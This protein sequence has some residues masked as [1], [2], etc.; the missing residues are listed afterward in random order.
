MLVS[1]CDARGAD[2]P[3]PFPAR[4][5]V[6]CSDNNDTLFYPVVAARKVSPS[7]ESV[8]PN[9]CPNTSQVRT[10]IPQHGPFQ[11]RRSQERRRWRG[12]PKVATT[13][14]ACRFPF[15]CCRHPLLLARTL[16]QV[17]YSQELR[18]SG[19]TGHWRT[20]SQ[21][22]GSVGRLVLVTGLPSAAFGCGSSEST[23]APR[24]DLCVS[25]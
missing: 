25:K 5:C 9:L 21:C 14:R 22:A 3:T 17:R 6:R 16:R 12:P 24:R 23:A 4:L 13:S 11:R 19:V 8:Q 1:R 10:P 18:W 2:P 20:R 15:R 7:T